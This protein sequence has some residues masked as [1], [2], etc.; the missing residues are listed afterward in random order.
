MD[1]GLVSA[2][3]SRQELWEYLL[4]IRP[5]AQVCNKLAAE[6]LEFAE[7][8]NYK[9]AIHLK[10]HMIIGGFLANESMEATII[11]WMQ[12]ICGMHKG[13]P[14]TFSGYGGA[15]SHTICLRVQHPEP[16][17]E[18]AHYLQVI[19]SYIRVNDCPP[20]KL[21]SQPH[22]SIASRLP[23][24][25]YHKAMPVYAQKQF[26]ETFMVTELLLLKRLNEFDACRHVNVFRFYPP[27]TNRYHQVA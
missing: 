2:S 9:A 23:A 24:G 10:P 13:F 12:R 27:D 22:L 5:D 7:R 1:N 17:S 8:F 16:F 26:N 4:V 6:K 25:I 19:D 20:L 15:S 3:S 18:L 21:V 14:V 11:K